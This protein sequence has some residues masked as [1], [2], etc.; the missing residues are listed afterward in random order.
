MAPLHRLLGSTGQKFVH[1]SCPLRLALSDGLSYSYQLQRAR[2]DCRISRLRNGLSP[3]SDLNSIV[4]H[5]PSAV[6]AKRCSLVL[7]E[8]DPHNRGDP[9]RVWGK[10]LWRLAAW[11]E[12]T[13]PWIPVRQ[14][15]I[16]NITLH[17]RFLR[18]Y[19]SD[20]LEVGRGSLP[21]EWQ[22]IM[23]MVQTVRLYRESP[24]QIIFRGANFPIGCTDYKFL[25]CDEIWGSNC[26]IWM[27]LLIT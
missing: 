23:S 17:R 13:C 22:L 14:R 15:D 9:G 6:L 3:L 25:H 8:A 18:R 11:L 27:W 7:M 10:T 5:A 1:S 19:H 4:R 2:R 26:I 24:G 12:V 21:E 16:N 20:W